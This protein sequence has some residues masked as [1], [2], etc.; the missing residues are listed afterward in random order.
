IGLPSLKARIAQATCKVVGANVTERLGGKKFT[1]PF[2]IEQAGPIKIAFLGLCF[3]R[4]EHPASWAVKRTDPID[5]A[6]RLVPEIRKR[7]DLVVAVTHIGLDEDQKLVAKVPGIDLVIG[8]HTHSVLPQGRT[9]K[10]SDGTQVL[11][12]QAGEE[13]KFLGQVDLTLSQ[14]SAQWRITQATAKLIPLD[15][16]IPLDPQVTALIARLAGA[17]TQPATSR[18]TVPP[19]GNPLGAEMDR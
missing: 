6:K 12:A 16:K 3:T 19:G 13:L 1:E 14:S 17:T 10:R 11:I 7:A 8:A 18:P 4:V 15:E 9:I 2:A 5:V